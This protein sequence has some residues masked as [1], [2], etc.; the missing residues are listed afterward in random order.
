[1]FHT[2]KITK[3]EVLTGCHQDEVSKSV[4]GFRDIIFNL[5]DMIRSGEFLDM[6]IV[7]PARQQWRGKKVAIRKNAALRWQFGI[8]YKLSENC[9][10]KVEVKAWSLISASA[11]TE[12]GGLNAPGT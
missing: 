5:S 8:E 12:D 2:L 9:V 10:T 11:T 4:Y 7:P 6:P 3:K 1:M